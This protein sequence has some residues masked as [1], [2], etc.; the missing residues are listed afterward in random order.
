MQTPECGQVQNDDLQP[1]IG[2]FGWE[3]YP[4]SA[5]NAHSTDKWSS[6][7]LGR[8]PP[9]CDDG[10][11]GIATWEYQVFSQS[12]DAKT[13]S[14]FTNW[15]DNC[16]FGPRCSIE[17]VEWVRYAK[18]HAFQLVQ[19]HLRVSAERQKQLYDRNSGTP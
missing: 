19:E 8:P 1:E 6:R 11:Q 12:H 16:Y 2:W 18:E 5:A 10:L 13:G 9:I 3:V 4:H 17:Y 15:F 7:W 14:N